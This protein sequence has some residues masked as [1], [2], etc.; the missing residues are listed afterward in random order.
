ME[1]NFQTSFIPKQT[2]V[3]T[4]EKASHGAGIFTMAAVIIF[5]T[6]VVA[7]GGLYFYKKVTEK[8]IVNMENDLN[9]A[10]NRFEP[11]KIFQLQVLDKRLRAASEVLGKHVAVSPI[12]E[13]LESITM[14]TVR[15]T[16]FRYTLSSDAESL[17][18]V[19]MSGEGVGYR[20]VALQADLFS[21]SKYFIDPVF[22]NLTLN[23]RG[24]VVFDLEFA[25]EPSFIDY[26][27]IVKAQ[28]APAIAP[29]N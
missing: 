20:S 14:K 3:E 15:F 9:L 4:R 7:S 5:L 17:V 23:S 29:S 24:N 12:F 25:V 18:E 22:S 13:A 26:Q 1:Q 28:S 8:R 2:V 27:E 21:Q 10:K 19:K 16:N 11:S 6:M